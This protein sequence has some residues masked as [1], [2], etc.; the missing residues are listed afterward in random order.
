[1]KNLIEFKDVI[2]KVEDVFPIIQWMRTGAAGAVSAK[3]LSREDT[4]VVG[5]IGTGRHGRSQLEAF[6]Y[7]KDKLCLFIFW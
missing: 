3:Y 5:F 7:S 6:Y 1:V 4:E 2:E